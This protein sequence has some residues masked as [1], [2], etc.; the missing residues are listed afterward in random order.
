MAEQP[1]IDNK[2]IEEPPGKTKKQLTRNEK[3]R[4]FLSGFAGWWVINGLVWLGVSSDYLNTMGESALLVFICVVPAFYLGQLIALIIL[5]YR[6]GWIAL[7]VTSA[8]ALN[9]VI[10][11][12]AGLTMN[13]TCFVPFFVPL[14]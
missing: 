8:I 3:I 10:T 7:G 5:A 13:A 12:V 4:D 2:G 9:L 1:E 6:R 14:Q 11:L